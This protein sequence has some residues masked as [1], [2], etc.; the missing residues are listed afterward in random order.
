M[1]NIFFQFFKNTSG[2][3]SIIKFRDII[4]S[5]NFDFFVDAQCRTRPYAV[6]END[7]WEESR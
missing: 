1:A 2:S 3:V 5:L 7:V 6:E 4:R